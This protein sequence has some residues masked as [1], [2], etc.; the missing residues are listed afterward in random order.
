MERIKLGIDGCSSRSRFTGTGIII[1]KFVDKTG[2]VKATLIGIEQGRQE[3][4]A[5]VLIA[6]ATTFPEYAAYLLTDETHVK[7]KHPEVDALA[8]ELPK[9]KRAK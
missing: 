3:P 5:G 8:G 4:K 6:I 2:I 9:Q 7:Q 1:R